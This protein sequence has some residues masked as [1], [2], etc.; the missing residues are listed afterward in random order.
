MSLAIGAFLKDHRYYRTADDLEA[1][2]NLVVTPNGWTHG[3]RSA[4]HVTLGSL[5]GRQAAHPAR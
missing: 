3:L 2:R 4:V 5:S 1:F